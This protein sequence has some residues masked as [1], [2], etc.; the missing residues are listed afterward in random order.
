M[1]GRSAGGARNDR[2]YAVYT[3]SLDRLLGIPPELAAATRKA[4]SVREK[5]GRTSRA[6]FERE[7]DRL[8]SLNS[9]LTGHYDELVAV[10]T[11]VGVVVPARLRATPQTSGVPDAVAA[12]LRDERVARTVVESQIASIRAAAAS[13][14]EALVQ[15]R[16]DAAAAADSLRSRQKKQAAARAAAADEAERVT[17]MAEARK[18]KQRIAL[19]AGGG[20]VSLAAVISA[21]FIGHVL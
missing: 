15:R 11:T 18:H 8:D 16:A 19:I 1:V 10:L 21:L 2:A 3:D 9:R 13:D 17:R 6:E 14:A 12:A 5:G 4:D 20:V 7:C